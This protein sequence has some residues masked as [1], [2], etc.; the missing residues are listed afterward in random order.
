M[1]F[2]VIAHLV[3]LSPCSC[4]DQQRCIDMHDELAVIISFEAAVDEV[5]HGI[6]ISAFT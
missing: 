4:L 1:S 5:S 2:V 3:P 6:A